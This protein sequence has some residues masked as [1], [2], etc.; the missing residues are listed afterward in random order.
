MSY[1]YI[2]YYFSGEIWEKDFDPVHVAMRALYKKDL[3]SA[4]DRYTE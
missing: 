1:I 3:Q 2:N 4:M